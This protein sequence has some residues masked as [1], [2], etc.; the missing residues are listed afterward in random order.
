[1]KIYKDTIGLWHIGDRVSPAGH[2]QLVDDH[3]G[4]LRIILSDFEVSTNLTELTDGDGNVFSSLTDLLTK[5]K[6]FFVD[7]SSWSGGLYDLN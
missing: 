2:N 4:N 5:C 7:A 6:D 3:D 1:M